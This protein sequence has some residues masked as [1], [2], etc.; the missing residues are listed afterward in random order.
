MHLM[1]T[2]V[3]LVFFF[4]CF[5][6][7]HATVTYDAQTGRLTIPEVRVEGD[8]SGT[9]F[10][11]TL[12]NGTN[13]FI[14]ENLTS[15]IDNTSDA[16]N[17]RILSPTSSVIDSAIELQAIILSSD[18]TW[19]DVTDVAEWSVDS[20]AVTLEGNTVYPT[21]YF[22]NGEEVTISATYYSGDGPLTTE[23]SKIVELPRRQ[24]F[25][26]EMGNL[27]S[28]Q[29]GGSPLL[30]FESIQIVI[31]N[32]YS[33]STSC[34]VEVGT[35]N[36]YE[37]LVLKLQ[38]TLMGCLNLGNKGSVNV[39]ILYNNPFHDTPVTSSLTGQEVPITP[40]NITV[41]YPRDSKTYIDDIFPY[42]YE[43]VPYGETYYDD[44]GNEYYYDLTVIMI[45]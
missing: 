6:D 12:L 42:P 15:F 18:G 41:I 26:I 17:F 24:D 9:V 23:I 2:L 38:D 16:D 36:N 25:I 39:E 37:E 29:N 33:S 14:I 34:D 22:T 11:A 32:Y 27:T 19:S 43:F 28:I 4:C 3:T 30:G 5:G 13:G 1:K 31:E 8:T 40:V 35:L 45:D 44:D 20:D 21:S 10:Q 7:V